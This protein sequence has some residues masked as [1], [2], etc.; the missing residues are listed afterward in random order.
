[1]CRRSA[2]LRARL[3]ACIDPDAQ[4]V[5]ARDSAPGGAKHLLDCVA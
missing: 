1:M 3:A 5:G 2:R 4:Q